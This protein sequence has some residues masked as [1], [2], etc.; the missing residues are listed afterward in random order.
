MEAKIHKSGSIVVLPIKYNF[1]YKVKSPN[2]YEKPIEKQKLHYKSNLLKITLK[3]GKSIRV[4]QDH[5]SIIIKN[6]TREEC[7]SSLLKVGNTFELKDGSYSKIEKI[8][9]IPYDGEVYDFTMPSE[10]FYSNEILTHNCR[11]RLDLRELR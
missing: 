11:L 2:G 8:E 9:K 6:K 10:M 1:N 4:T 7:E 3:N 5:L